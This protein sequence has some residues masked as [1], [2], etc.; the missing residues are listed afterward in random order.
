MED[1]PKCT[2]REILS[3]KTH[4][5]HYIHSYIWVPPVCQHG[6]QHKDYGSEQERQSSC[7]RWVSI[8]LR[9]LIQIKIYSE[10]EG[11]KCHGGGKKNRRG[12]RCAGRGSWWDRH[13]SKAQGDWGTQPQRWSRGRV[14]QTVGQQIQGLRQECAWQLEEIMRKPECL[15]ALNRLQIKGLQFGAKCQHIS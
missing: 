5:E 8:L 3:R 9:R 6:P 11:V 12:A 1:F 14:V 13:L 7:L 4:K 10:L 2:E 15:K